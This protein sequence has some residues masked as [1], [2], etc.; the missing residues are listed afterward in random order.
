MVHQMENKVW[1]KICNAKGISNKLQPQNRQK[2]LNNLLII[3]LLLPLFLRFPS[4]LLVTCIQV[5]KLCCQKFIPAPLPL[6]FQYLIIQ[7]KWCNNSMAQKN[8][9]KNACYNWVQTL[10]L[11]T[12]AQIWIAG[13]TV[14]FDTVIAVRTNRSK[15]MWTYVTSVTVAHRK[16]KDYNSITISIISFVYSY[17]KHPTPS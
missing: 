9:Q 1:N 7:K 2:I 12:V 15:V 6:P 5:W 13:V 17:P 4:P 3:C 8:S 16:R 11:N 14:T 10:L